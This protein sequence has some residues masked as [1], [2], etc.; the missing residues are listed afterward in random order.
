MN[1]RSKLCAKA[2]GWVGREFQPGRS[3]QCAAWV[4]ACL[5]SIGYQGEGSFDWRP[6]EWV[7]DYSGADNGRPMGARVGIKELEPGDLLIW[8]YT[9]T[10]QTSTHI[11]IYVGEGRFVH[12]PTAAR[13]VE[14]GWLLSGYWRDK[15]ECGIKLL[16]PDSINSPGGS[17]G[18]GEQG[19][20]LHRLRLEAH[21]GRHDF[22]VD[23]SRRAVERFMTSL[24]LA[25]DGRAAGE[26]QV[27]TKQ[28]NLMFIQHQPPGEQLRQS[29]KLDGQ[30]RE[31]VD[32]AL[33]THA[34]PG[35]PLGLL[36]DVVYK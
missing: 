19:S 22:R 17:D 11:G 7:P 12:R 6:S 34:V 30:E 23:G 33:D 8:G 27:L 18:A 20:E 21:S 5:L 2:L 4:S 15:F 10:S 35:K 14:E 25:E 26:I 24:A 3:A 16:P 13:P 1:W 29:L 9:Y 32:V 28:G 31:L 36:L